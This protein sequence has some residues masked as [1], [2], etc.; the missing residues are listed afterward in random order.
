MMMMIYDEDNN[1]DGGDVDNDDDSDECDEK[2]LRFFRLM[3]PLKSN[4]KVWECCRQ[5]EMEL[6]FQRLTFVPETSRYILYVLS[7][8]RLY[9]GGQAPITKL[10]A[11]LSL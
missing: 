1:D 9:I 8:I 3:T 10:S 6:I 5:Y 11:H 4:L 7:S 2:Q